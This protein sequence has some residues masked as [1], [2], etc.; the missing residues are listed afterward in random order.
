MAT[1]ETTLTIDDAGAH[2][3][4]FPEPYT[5]LK[6][7]NLFFFLKSCLAATSASRFDCVVWANE[8]Y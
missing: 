1:R 2:F 5:H 6:H 3:I 7:T 4:M 8:Q